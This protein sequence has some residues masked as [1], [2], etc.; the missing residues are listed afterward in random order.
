LVEG[1]PL[2]FVFEA[3]TTYLQV[4]F[5]KGLTRTA[6]GGREDWRKGEEEEGKKGEGENDCDGNF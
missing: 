4:P 3:N 1:H 6:C 5:P 2:W